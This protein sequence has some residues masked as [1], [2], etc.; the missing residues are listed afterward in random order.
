MAEEQVENINIEKLDEDD[1]DRDYCIENDD[2]NYDKMTT[3]NMLV[4][5]NIQMTIFQI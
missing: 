4:P 3:T 5:K 2:H 1:D